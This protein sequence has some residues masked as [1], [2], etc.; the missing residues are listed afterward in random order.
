MHKVRPF[1]VHGHFSLTDC[2]HCGY[3][4]PRGS[5]VPI[6]EFGSGRER[7]PLFASRIGTVG[8]GR[9]ALACHRLGGGDRSRPIDPCGKAPPKIPDDLLWSSRASVPTMWRNLIYPQNFPSLSRT[10]FEIAIGHNLFAGGVGNILAEPGT[11]LGA[12]EIRVVD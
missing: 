4:L 7:P 8:A 6:G 9:C 2:P 12:I 1:N 11:R 3:C 10:T 5:A